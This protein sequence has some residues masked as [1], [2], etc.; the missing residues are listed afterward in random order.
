MKRNVLP[1][2]GYRRQAAGRA[3]R[4]SRASRAGCASRFDLRRPEYS[5][6]LAM[7]LILTELGVLP[8]RR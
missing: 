5:G 2:T 1:A 6:L 3:S 4:A 7:T 8:L